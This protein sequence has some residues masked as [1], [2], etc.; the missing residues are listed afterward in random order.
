MSTATSSP[1]VIDNTSQNYAA[2][3]SSA[4]KDP[5]LTTSS[6]GED[7]LIGVGIGRRSIENDEEGHLSPYQYSVKEEGD[8]QA[9]LASPA[10]PHISPS[11]SGSIQPSPT[12]H[13]DF[14]S[15]DY[16]DNSHSDFSAYTTPGEESAYVF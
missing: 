14:R 7:Q 8:S 5:F 13:Q 6:L 4:F 9:R 10:H 15:P 1:R 11:H 3:R 12:S 2:F 16:A